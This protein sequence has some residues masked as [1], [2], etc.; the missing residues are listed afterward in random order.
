[1]QLGCTG[2]I[3]SVLLCYVGQQTWPNAS[4]KWAYRMPLLVCVCLP[5]VVLTL[6]LFLLCESPSWLIMHGKTAK[7]K[8]TLKFMYPN[9]TDEQRELIYAEYEYTLGQEAEKNKMV[10]VY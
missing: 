4:N 9:R 3:I 5:V 1:M 8:K 2:D 6:Q 10:R 7:A